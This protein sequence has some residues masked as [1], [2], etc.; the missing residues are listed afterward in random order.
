M[1]EEN[2]KDDKGGQNEQLAEVLK[3]LPGTIQKSVEA[4]LSAAVRQHETANAPLDDLDDD[5]GADSD[6]GQGSGDEITD[7]DLEAMDNVQL[8]KHVVGSVR[9]DIEKLFKTRDKD[10]ERRQLASDKDRIAGNIKEARGAHD[11]FD[12]FIPDMAKLATVYPNLAVE[13]LY[14]LIC[15]SGFHVHPRRCVEIVK[16][17]S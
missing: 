1:A 16:A 10:T 9:G 5:T 4:G 12:S 11:D 6:K 3:A 7:E 14:D 15:D 17:L 8:V 13:H 2:G